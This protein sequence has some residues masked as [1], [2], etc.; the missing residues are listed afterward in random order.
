MFNDFLTIEGERLLA[1]SIAGTATITFTKMMVGDG[2]R[3][4][5]TKAITSLENPK[6]T[7][8]EKNKNIFNLGVDIVQL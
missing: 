4:T 7:L 5:S 2:D 3:G 8:F 1:K 6:I